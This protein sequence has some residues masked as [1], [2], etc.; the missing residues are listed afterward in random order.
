V[1]ERP[2]EHAS[3]ACEGNPLRGF[4]SHRHRTGSKAASHPRRHRRRYGPAVYA[5]RGLR[6]AGM[7]IAGAAAVAFAVAVLAVVVWRGDLRAVFGITLMV[8]AALLAVTGG[9]ALSRAV[10]ADG[11]AMMGLPPENEDPA[12]GP[13]LAPFGVFLFVC[14]PLFVLGGLL[15]G[16]G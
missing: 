4:K 12:S 15:Y 11:R 9:N 16:A 13:A 10:G 14:V 6:Q 3:K 5:L 8:I 2:K 1:S 7:M